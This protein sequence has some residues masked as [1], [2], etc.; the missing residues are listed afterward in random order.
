MAQD[1]DA[2]NYPYIRIRNV[3]WLKQT[4][5]VFPHVARI[6][7]STGG[8]KDDA[9]VAQ[10]CDL[11]GRRDL[12]LLRNVDLDKSNIWNDQI[13]LKALISDALSANG[14]QFRR[15]FG[16]EAT[17]NDVDLLRESVSLWDDRLASRAFQLHGQNVVQTLLDFL[18]QNDLAWDPQHSH[19]LGYV[20]MHP[21]LGE[22]VLA[23]L[24]F[25]CARSEGL[26]LV[27]EFPQIYGRTIH[28][29][30]DEIFESIIGL[31]PKDEGIT[32]Q[33][34]APENLVEFVVHQRCDVSNLTPEKLLELNK[35]W[36]AMGAFRD[37]LEK[38][39]ADIP[40]GIEDPKILHQYYRE[41]ADQMFARWKQ[42]SKNLP[43]RVKDLFAGSDDEVMKVLGRVIEKSFDG[44]EVAI[45]GG[46]GTLFGGLTSSTLL[47]VGAGLALAVVFRIGKNMVAQKK[48]RREDPIIRFLTITADAGV[49]YVASA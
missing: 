1:M 2:L 47:G 5:I 28:R 7:P 39:A 43:Q 44:K 23:T 34:L 17:C 38:L 41:R 46:A 33:A 45:V 48:K 18:F 21:R 13:E 36:E 12:P 26:R 8:P 15:Q 9:E 31:T 11:I 35:N 6:A 24:A 22:A 4:L 37:S 30:K 10:F 42:D 19:G 27:T 14:D 25:A 20:E 3:E 32:E 16:R 40:Q 49:T 29:S